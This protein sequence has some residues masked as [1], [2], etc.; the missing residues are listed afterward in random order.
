V[1]G[2]DIMAQAWYQGGVSV[3]DFTDSSHPVEIAFFDRGPIDADHLFTGGFWSA[4]WYNGYLYGSEIAR[5]VDVFRLTPSEFLTKNE[6]E[7]AALVRLTEFNPQHQ[8]RI[9]WPSSLV[10][11]RAYLDQLNRDKAINPEHASAVKSAIDNADRRSPSKGA[12]ENLST[13]ATELDSDRASAQGHDAGTIV[14][15]V[16]VLKEKGKR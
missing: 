13:V 5:G 15:L 14:A 4:Y 11:A 16:E 1:P 12:L 10:V 6:I 9:T 3:F 8:S 2:R 7:A